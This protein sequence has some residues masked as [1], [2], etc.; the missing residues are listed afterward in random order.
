MDAGY[1]RHSRVVSG[2]MRVYLVRHLFKMYLK[3]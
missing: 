2:K 1:I 3:F